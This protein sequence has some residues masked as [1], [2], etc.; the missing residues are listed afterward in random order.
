MYV[1]AGL[2]EGKFW[3]L[4]KNGIASYGQPTKDEEN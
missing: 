1:A 2:N 4:F 3:V